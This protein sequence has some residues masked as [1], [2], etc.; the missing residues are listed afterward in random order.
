VSERVVKILESDI[1][2]P[3]NLLTLADGQSVEFVAV[4][5]KLGWAKREITVGARRT[6]VE[7]PIL[8]VFCRP[9][10]FVF[11]APYIDI[12]AGRTIAS[13]T[14]LFSTVKPPVKLT[15]IAHGV[16]PDKWYEIKWELGE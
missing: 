16:E 15:L 1:K 3:Y 13:L 4:D 2:G 14:S 6:V 8:R 7:G 12:L 5:Y 11:G 9:G 10:T